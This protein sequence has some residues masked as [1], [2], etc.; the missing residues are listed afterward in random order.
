MRVSDV[1]V[2]V[3]NAATFLYGCI[4]YET[5]ELNLA[6]IIGLVV[7][8][9]VLLFLVIAVVV[10]CVYRRRGIQ[11]QAADDNSN[12]VEMSPVEASRVDP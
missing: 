8:L 2:H 5:E 7:G 6:W 11:K 3:G 9:G 4:R 12:D 10:V 1:K